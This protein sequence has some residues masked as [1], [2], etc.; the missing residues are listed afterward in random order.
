MSK[1]LAVGLNFFP[2]LTGIGKY[3]GELTAYLVAKGHIVHVITTP[4]YY[5]Q[6]QVQPGYRWWAY[7]RE[8]W[9]GVQIQRCPLWVPHRPSGLK[10]LAHLSSYALSSLPALLGQLTWHPDIVLCIAPAFFSV[11]FAWLT[12]RITGAKC[13]LHI[14]DFELDA[15]TNLGM[16][17]RVH[18]FTCWA[19]Q[20]ESWLL[21]RFDRVSSIS[22]SMVSRLLQ[23]G[24]SSRQV[25][26][27]PNWVDTNEIFPI[28]P[29]ENP[30]R[31]AMGIPISQTI[32]LYSGNLGRKQGLEVLILAAKQLQI[33]PN[34]HF[35]L[36]GDGVARAELE[37]AARGLP[38]VQFLPLQPPEKL[39]LLLNSADIHI[40]PQR[41]DAADLV[42]PSKLLGMLASGKAVI[43]TANLGSE[44]GDVVGQ[45][46]VSVAPGDQLAL[47]RAILKLA[48]SHQLRLHLGE[49][50]RDYVCKNWSK[51]IVLSRFESQ[52]QDVINA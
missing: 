31:K 2:E 18:F 30:M 51:P 3:T 22:E 45:V 33:Y 39:N 24:V 48:A 8:S 27:F 46:G 10:R 7:Q 5:P 47:C 32:I 49:K 9:Q 37:I 1:I 14:Q 16:L 36:C 44:L 50:G 38:N 13:W 34:L 28:Q 29:S 26:L 25:V 6:W 15:A 4:P 12:A 11:P 23:K 17:P 52:L 43:A 40:L 35:I 19:A 42:M 21:G 41:A 20:G